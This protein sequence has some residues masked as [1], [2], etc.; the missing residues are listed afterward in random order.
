MRFLYSNGNQSLSTTS[1][2]PEASLHLILK[3]IILPI[4][5][6]QSFYCICISNLIKSFSG[7]TFFLEGNFKLNIF[8][9]VISLSL[10]SPTSHSDCKSLSIRSE[11]RI[12]CYHLPPLV[13]GKARLRIAESGLHL[14]KIFH[15]HLKITLLPISHKSIVAFCQVLPVSQRKARLRETFVFEDL[16]DF[17]LHLWLLLCFFFFN[18]LLER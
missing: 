1:P 3:Y 7:L 5:I 8:F 15:K 17:T 12:P 18:L 4:Q 13:C 14:Q 10:S 9:L 16:E 6:C 11:T 2:A